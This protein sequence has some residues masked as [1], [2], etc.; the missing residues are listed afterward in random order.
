MKK[1]AI[2]LVGAVTSGKTTLANNLG[3]ILNFDIINEEK[4]GNYFK[5]IKEIDGNKHPRAIYDHCYIYTQ[6]AHFSKEYDEVLLCFINLSETLLVK[7]YENRKQADKHQKGDYLKINPVQQ[8]NNLN[9]EMKEWKN[10]FDLLPN[11]KFV[12][13]PITDIDDY[14]KLEQKLLT[15]VENSV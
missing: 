13:E 8:Q 4:F 7:N 14:I 5:I 6:V 11:I 12:P 1:L 15:L 2:V 9:F 3:Q 10:L